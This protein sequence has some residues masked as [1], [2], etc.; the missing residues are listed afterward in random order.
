MNFLGLVCQLPES[1]TIDL[2][3][4]VSS[5]SLTVI[6]ATA[7]EHPEDRCLVTRQM[8]LIFKHAVLFHVVVY[9]NFFRGAEALH[10]PGIKQKI[11]PDAGLFIWYFVTNT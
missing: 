1:L 9:I 2:S 4:W 10:S 11:P 3:I 6:E 5:F 8:L 7:G